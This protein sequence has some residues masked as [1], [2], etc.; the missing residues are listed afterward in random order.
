MSICLLFAVI[1]LDVRITG[2][3]HVGHSLRFVNRVEEFCK[4]N[5]LLVRG[6]QTKESPPTKK[7]KKKKKKRW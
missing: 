7:K 2:C 6:Y 1:C 5:L 4:T 3:G